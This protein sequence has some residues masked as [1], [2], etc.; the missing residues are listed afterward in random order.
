[1]NEDYY[2][3]DNSYINKVLEDRR[4][5]PI[6]LSVVWL[7]TARRLNLPIAGINLPGHFM[8]KYDVPKVDIYIDPFNGGKLLSRLDCI[9]FMVNAGY[10]FS[11]QH[12]TPATNRQIIIRMF[13]NLAEIYSQKNDELHA[14]PIKKAVTILS[15][16]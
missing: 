16:Y 7:L 12:L 6:S 11:E 10:K 4:G 5:I 1:N 8:L 14:E 15:E 9:R 2:N 13:N 3:P